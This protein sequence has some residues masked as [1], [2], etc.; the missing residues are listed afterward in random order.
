MAVHI[1]RRQQ[2][3]LNL[4]YHQPLYKKIIKN[5]EIISKL[6]LDEGLYLTIANVMNTSA[7][8]ENEST[9]AGN[10]HK[11]SAFPTKLTILQQIAKSQY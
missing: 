11:I 7:G 4:L 5:N 8:G 10:N 2:L 6:V 1:I 3:L 9:A